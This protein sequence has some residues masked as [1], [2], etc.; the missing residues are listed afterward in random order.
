MKYLGLRYEETKKSYYT[1]GRQK[2]DLIK[3]Q[4]KHGGICW[5][6]IPYQKETGAET[7]I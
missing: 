5:C 3:D 7:E 4:Q 1:N 2:E 6:I